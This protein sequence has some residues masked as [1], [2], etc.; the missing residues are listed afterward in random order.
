MK[1]ATVNKANFQRGK[2]MTKA[3]KATPTWCGERY[4]KERQVLLKTWFDTANL[5]TNYYSNAELREL[6]ASTLGD[7]RHQEN[8]AETGYQRLAD[9]NDLLTAYCRFVLPTS[10]HGRASAH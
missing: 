9:V 6:I 7:L 3:P 2:S 8:E 4:D 5:I 1:N 10:E